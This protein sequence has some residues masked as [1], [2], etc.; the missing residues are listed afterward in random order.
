MSFRNSGSHLCCKMS[1]LISSHRKAFLA[2]LVYSSVL[3]HRYRRR[4]DRRD[5]VVARTPDD[6]EDFDALMTTASRHPIPSSDSIESLPSIAPP[7][8]PLQSIQQ[9]FLPKTTGIVTHDH[10]WGPINPSRIATALHPSP[11][12]VPAPSER[13]TQLKDRRTELSTNAMP[14]MPAEELDGRNISTRSSRTPRRAP[15]AVEAIGTARHELPTPDTR[16]E[17]AADRDIWC[18]AKSL[19]VRYA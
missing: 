12:A 5:T 19:A 15:E 9:I 17:M 6:A 1:L 11:P 4:H 13:L 7:P 3:Y 16:Y 2:H 8:P 10:Q 14:E 18:K